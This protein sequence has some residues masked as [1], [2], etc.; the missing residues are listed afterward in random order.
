MARR[1]SGPHRLVACTES[2][3]NSFLSELCLF[4]SHAS[5][6][7]VDAFVDALNELALGS[8]HVLNDL[9]DDA[10]PTV[11]RTDERNRR[12]CAGSH[13]SPCAAP[14]G[15]RIPL[16]PR[17]VGAQRT[18]THSSARIGIRTKSPPLGQRRLATSGPT[19]SLN[20]RTTLTLFRARSAGALYLLS[21]RPKN[22]KAATGPLA[23]RGF[24]A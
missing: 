18:A 2:A 8:S 10:G 21:R 6:D 1:P 4:P 24:A 12:R 19:T 16:I 13:R 3:R 14:E 9:W 22:A 7:Q 5:D 20:D 15:Y 17:G 23:D 11:Q